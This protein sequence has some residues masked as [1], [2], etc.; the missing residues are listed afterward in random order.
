MRAVTIQVRKSDI[1]SHVTWHQTLTLTLQEC[2]SIVPSGML[3]T[4][5]ISDVTHKVAAQHRS[6]V[7]ICTRNCGARA[8]SLQPATVLRAPAHSPRRRRQ[9]ETLLDVER[10]HCPVGDARVL[11][12]APLCPTSAGS[13]SYWMKLVLSLLC[14]RVDIYSRCCCCRF[15]SS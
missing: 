6:S 1:F 13:G 15:Y 7:P 10:E 3:L 2:N 14:L 8:W 4:F 5:R 9:M 12:V 11:P